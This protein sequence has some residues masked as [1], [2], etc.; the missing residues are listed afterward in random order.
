MLL[1]LGLVS[2]SLADRCV[3]TIPPRELDTWHLNSA[4]DDT[5]MNETQAA[6]V[7]PDGA[8][9]RPLRPVSVGAAPL[10]KI[11]V[12]EVLKKRCVAFEGG[13]VLAAQV[14][15][16]VPSRAGF[17]IAATVKNLAV[18]ISGSI[19]FDRNLTR[20]SL[21]IASLV[22][23]SAGSFALQVR[24]DDLGN[25][26]L[27]Q[28]RGMSTSP[29]ATIGDWHVVLIHRSLTNDSVDLWVN[30]TRHV[31]YAFSGTAELTLQPLWIGNHF[32]VPNRTWTGRLLEL[33]IYDAELTV[34]EV[35]DVSDYLARHWACNATTTTRTAPATMMMSKAQATTIMAS[36]TTTTTTTRREATT[37]MAPTTATTARSEATAGFSTT[38]LGTI[39]TTVTGTMSPTATAVSDANQ[40]SDDTLVIAVGAGVG[41][42][43]FVALL[44]AGLVLL[45]R[46][47]RHSGASAAKGTHLAQIENNYGAVNVTPPA[48]ITGNYVSVSASVSNSNDRDYGVGQID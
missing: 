39:S 47:R 32:N 38:T 34:E 26:A 18:P 40:R 29:R 33:L 20:T 13:S 17:L 3:T 35:A 12:D 8:K 4:L 43:C 28:V 25:L 16:G 14:A 19:V 27:A 10:P 44:G 24:G 23:N 42:V 15:P 45:C 46:R 30:G 1:V 2:V 11:V 6:F 9:L 31:S 37:I 48:C 5:A 21:P 22:L 41:G 7:W 36:T